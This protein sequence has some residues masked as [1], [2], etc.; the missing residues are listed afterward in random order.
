M[1]QVH[2]DY[3]T[4]DGSTFEIS[5][6]V[7]PGCPGVGVSFAGPGEPPDPPMLEDVLVDGE[8]EIEQLFTEA[9]CERI[10][11]QLWEAADE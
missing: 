8:K 11:E 1:K 2:I 3:E 9:E 4:E 10:H 6:A 7:I 5:A